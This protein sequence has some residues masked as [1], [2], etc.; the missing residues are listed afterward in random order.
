[1]HRTRS[2]R[3]SG[4]WREAKRHEFGGNGAVRLNRVSDEDAP[5]HKADSEW[6]LI[7]L[8]VYARGPTLTQLALTSGPPHRLPRPL[9]HLPGTVHRLLF[10]VTK[11]QGVRL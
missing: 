5:L 11:L 4:S 1:M 8:G 2:G 9:S 3:R 7:P 10:S 6:L